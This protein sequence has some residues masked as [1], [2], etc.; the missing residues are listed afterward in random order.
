MLERVIRHGKVEPDPW[1]IV[2]VTSPDESTGPLPAGPILVPLTFWIERRAWLASR[3][4]PVGV[5]LRPGDEPG[6]LADDL[7]SLALVAV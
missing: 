5:W 7:S 4:E 1:T 6:E 3:R 2:G